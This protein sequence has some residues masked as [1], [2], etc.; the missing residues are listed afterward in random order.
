[1]QRRKKIDK[2]Y[3]M[4]NMKYLNGKES[5]KAFFASFG[6]ISWQNQFKKKAGMEL[7]A[8]TT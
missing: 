8:P 5:N 6:S 7:R 2:S 1:M 3:L 4:N